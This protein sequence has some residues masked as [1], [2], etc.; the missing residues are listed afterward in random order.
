MRPQFSVFIAMSL[1]GF[2]ARENGSFDFLSI[3][4]P[5]DESHGYDAF[6]QTVDTLVIGR[7]TYEV[8]LGF[9]AWPYPGKKVIVLTHQKRESKYGETFFSGPVGELAKLDSKRVYVDGGN[10]ISQF[11]AAG[12]IDDMTI[13]VIP[14]V[15]GGG[16]RL[17]PGGEGEHRLKLEGHRS[18]SS[19]MVQV[20]YRLS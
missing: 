5:V 20:R 15:L 7:G 8:A 16:I 13:S 11:L 1:D 2:I 12:L 9:G 18:W 14:I 6:I 3:V 4:D 19:G 10:A 17:F